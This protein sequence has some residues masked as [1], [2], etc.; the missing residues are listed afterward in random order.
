M[1]TKKVGLGVIVFAV[2]TASLSVIS[3][4]VVSTPIKP[5]DAQG[6]KSF[7]C[8]P[9]S[10]CAY[11]YHDCSR[12]EIELWTTQIVGCGVGSGGWFIVRAVD[13]DGMP[14][15]EKFCAGF[16]GTYCNPAPSSAKWAAKYA[17]Q[18]VIDILCL[19]E[20]GCLDTCAE[21]ADLLDDCTD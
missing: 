14:I 13:C 1:F 20:Y 3:R 8:H 6:P 19:P 17:N 21:C 5:A 15:G 2:I 9:P 16:V 11:V 12:P 10:V 4:T 18:E 7:G